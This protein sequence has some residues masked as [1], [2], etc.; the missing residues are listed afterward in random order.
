MTKLNTP[1]TKAESLARNRKDE[2]GMGVGQEVFYRTLAGALTHQ[3]AIHEGLHRAVDLIVIARCRIKEAV[4]TRLHVRQD[5][6]GP[7]RQA[8]HTHAKA[9]DQHHRKA[10]EENLG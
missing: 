8:D 4:H 7:D 3:A 5:Q 1:T 2:V 10:R 9:K 6:I